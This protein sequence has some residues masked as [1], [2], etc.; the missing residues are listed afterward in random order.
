M[1]YRA[2]AGLVLTVVLSGCPKEKEDDTLTFAEALQAVEESTLSSQAQ[3]LQSASVEITTSFTIGQAVEN[4]AQEIKDF[5]GTQLPCAEITLADATLTVK[6]GAKP[7]NCTYKG[8]KFSGTHSI[9]VEKNDQAQ[10]LVHHTW[11]DLTNGVVKLNG[12]ADVTWDFQELSRKVVHKVEWTRVHDGF[13]VSGEGDRTQTPL[14]GGVLEGIEIDGHRSWA[15]VRGEWNLTI[16]GV[17]MRWVDPVPQA[18][19][20]NLLTP[21]NKKLGLSFQR[22]DED[23]IKVTVSNGKRSFNFDVSKIGTV[24]SS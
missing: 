10:V 19:S 5:V 22:V 20:Y 21:K 2:L 7:G 1:R 11:A 23:T 8:H 4:A 14:A 6:Y 15:S 16:D 3:S 13:A 9:Q 18:G 12:T 24:K 17:Q